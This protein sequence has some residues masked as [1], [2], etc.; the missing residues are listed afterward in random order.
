[1]PGVMPGAE[2]AEP[3]SVDEARAKAE[4]RKREQEQQRAE[5]EAAEAASQRVQQQR[6]QLREQQQQQ[7]EREAQA[8]AREQERARERARERERFAEDDAKAKEAL[9]AEAEAH[10]KKQQE[11]AKEAAAAVAVAA[12]AVK[13]AAVKAP[14]PSAPSVG[15]VAGAPPVR[16]PAQAMTDLMG[17]ELGRFSP[18][19]QTS[20]THLRRLS[21]RIG[22]ARELKVG[23]DGKLRNDSG[24]GATKPGQLRPYVTAFLVGSTGKRLEGRGMVIETSAPKPHLTALESSPVWN[25]RHVMPLSTEALAQLGGHLTPQGSAAALGGSSAA[26]VLV[27]MDAGSGRTGWLGGA[28]GGA[29]PDVALAQARVEWNQ[30]AT[31]NMFEKE[32]ELPLLDEFGRK[33]GATLSVRAE[34]VDLQACQTEISTLNGRLDGARQAIAQLVEQR[35]AA[36]VRLAH[37]MRMM[38]TEMEH[39]ARQAASSEAAGIMRAM[40]SQLLEFVEAEEKLCSDVEAQMESEIGESLGALDAAVEASAELL[41]PEKGFYAAEAPALHQ[42][43]AFELKTGTSELISYAQQ[44]SLRLVRIVGDG[45]SAALSLCE[46]RLHQATDYQLILHREAMERARVAAAVW[47]GMP[48]AMVREELAHAQS[49]WSV[50][51][52]GLRAEALAAAAMMHGALV[53]LKLGHDDEGVARRERQQ[54]NDETLRAIL[55]DFITWMHAETARAKAEHDEAASRFQEVT[56]EKLGA[57]E[58][59]GE[60]RV[61]LAKAGLERIESVVA[62]SAS[63]SAAEAAVCDQVAAEEA[64]TRVLLLEEVHGH[65]LN[66]MCRWIADT[67]EESRGLAEAA[68]VQEKAAAVEARKVGDELGAISQVEA[69]SRDMEERA[70]REHIE[71]VARM[72]AE[73]GPQFTRL[74]AAYEH[75]MHAIRAELAALSS[76]AISEHVSTVRGNMSE[77]IELASRLRA[78]SAAR[79]A[80]VGAKLLVLHLEHIE[81]SSIANAIKLQGAYEEAVHSVRLAHFKTGTETEITLLRQRHQTL[82][83]F[84][85]IASGAFE[86]SWE[87]ERAQL[88]AENAAIELGRHALVRQHVALAER[89]TQD[90]YTL[91]AEQY[92]KWADAEAADV[93]ARA[94]AEARLAHRRREEPGRTRAEQVELHRRVVLSGGAMLQAETERF[95]SARREAAEAAT[96][97]IEEEAA[98]A[99]ELVLAAQREWR[100]QVREG[101][102]ADTEAHHEGLLASELLAHSEAIERADAT[103]SRMRE[104]REMTSAALDGR[105]FRQLLARQQHE[106]IVRMANERAD[107]AVAKMKAA[108]EA[109][110]RVADET[111]TKVAAAEEKAHEALLKA[112]AESSNLLEQHC[113]LHSARLERAARERHQKAMNA[114]D[115]ARASAGAELHQVRAAALRGQDAELQLQAEEE[116]ALSAQVAAVVAS[117]RV[118]HAETLEKTHEAMEELNAAWLAEHEASFREGEASAL[119]WQAKSSER[120]VRQL[121]STWCRQRVH[122]ANLC[123]DLQRARR[124]AFEGRRAKRAEAMYRLEGSLAAEQAE[125]DAATVA[126]RRALAQEARRTPAK[127]MH[128]AQRALDHLAVKK[129]TKTVATLERRY[130]MAVKDE[131]AVIDA[132]GAQLDASARLTA[133]QLQELSAAG[134]KAVGPAPSAFVT[135]VLGG[136]LAST[137]PDKAE[138][139]EHWEAE[140]AGAMRDAVDKA[141][142]DGLLARRARTREAALD[143][144]TRAAARE[145]TERRKAMAEAVQRLQADDAKLE[146]ES[147][148]PLTLQKEHVA[149]FEVAWDARALGQH[150]AAEELMRFYTNNAKRVMPEAAARREAFT[151]ARFTP[152]TSLEAAFV[153]YATRAQVQ[154]LVADEAFE[155]EAAFYQASQALEARHAAE[156]AQVIKETQARREAQLER[157]LERTASQLDMQIVKLSG[158]QLVRATVALAEKAANANDRAS[159][160]RLQTHY[161]L[162]NAAKGAAKEALASARST[163]ALKTARARLELSLAEAETRV[164]QAEQHGGSPLSSFEPRPLPP[165]P[166]SPV[167]PVSPG[168]PSARPAGAKPSRRKAADELAKKRQEI[169][170]EIAEESDEAT[171]A[172]PSKGKQRPASAGKQ[173]PASNGKQRPAPPSPAAAKASP[174]ASPAKNKAPGGDKGA[175]RAASA[176]KARPGK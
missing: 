54:R 27:L 38:T 68:Q 144:A 98:L 141:V 55:G 16:R 44:A 135:Q 169:A 74:E 168:E 62:E 112:A 104:L 76:A 93:A 124:D 45:H 15:S 165:S 81:Q 170:E 2:N 79:R 89:Q 111:V 114:Y 115:V 116:E 118:V 77:V 60:G 117:A 37:E 13:A 22:G 167:S 80:D 32:L 82:T 11:A 67:E 50:R 85:G 92:D 160:K 8:R 127:V 166:P 176:P 30:L 138:W 157:E 26:L 83:A 49:C 6:E 90:H 86:A 18:A 9:R 156:L 163:G 69:R 134:T 56:A 158:P 107:R 108:H 78:K 106:T 148:N 10:R 113:S 23:P 172:T 150:A 36:D 40:Q 128:A 53:E 29:R 151:A 58:R 110:R 175:A 21:I 146:A 102:L 162:L 47:S 14:L 100:Q 24:A 51:Q 140:E 5:R 123:R 131:K 41:H 94:A 147:A 71:A 130:Q 84:H 73:V 137:A 43:I 125:T 46:A 99:D 174:A 33:T 17:R 39:D 155:S 164:R 129:I 126:A 61:A 136:A 70:R 120:F 173:R 35:R 103:M 171:G 4:A 159:L 52:Q 7:A 48:A 64:R 119:E 149:Q 12:A 1:M 91:M 154:R 101:M 122:Y 63:A 42:V 59:I 142:A 95:V 109:A 19:L 145:A 66:V 34:L 105:A 153:A 161:Q 97:R 25:E 88:L 143:D 31:S 132:V 28:L 133:E 20:V 87:R 121:A 3:Q 65:R 72:H 96:I 75:K 152:E 57:L 139:L